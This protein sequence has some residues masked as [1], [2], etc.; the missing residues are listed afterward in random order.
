MHVRVLGADGAGGA[1]EELGQE[2]AVAAHAA[3]GGTWRRAAPAGS[4][5]WRRRRLAAPHEAIDR[6]LSGDGCVGHP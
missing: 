1:A 2:A 6:V 3:D 4:G 5:A